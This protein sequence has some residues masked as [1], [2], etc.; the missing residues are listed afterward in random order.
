MSH[1]TPRMLLLH[2]GLRLCRAMV[3]RDWWLTGSYETAERLLLVH[4]INRFLRDN[5]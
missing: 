1:T 2:P 5:D 4:G 3:T